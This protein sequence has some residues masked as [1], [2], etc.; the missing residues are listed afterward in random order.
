MDALTQLSQREISQLSLVDVRYLLESNPLLCPGV[1]GSDGEALGHELRR[2][3]LSSLSAPASWPAPSPL[4]LRVGRYAEALLNTVTGMKSAVFE[5]R[6]RNLQI[7][8][9]KQT[10]GELDLVT[11]HPR[12]NLHVELAVKLY[13]GL[14]KYQASL[15]GWVGPN[16]RDTL[17][18][19]FRH[20]R[21]KQLPLSQSAAAKAALKLRAEA[22]LTQQAW[23]KG[24]LFHYHSIIA[25]QLPE[26]INPQ[27]HSG[28]WT[29]DTD[30]WSPPHHSDLIYCIPPKPFW[31]YS[32]PQ[33]TPVYNDWK[34]L[35]EA[36]RPHIE[37]RLTAHVLILTRSSNEVVSRG[38]IASQQW[39][40]AA[41]DLAQSLLA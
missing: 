22:S 10:I 21:D 9:G 13:L 37:K 24:Y 2:A 25:D 18:K 6:A 29:L 40:Q 26:L 15:D 17:G 7:F 39:L 31:I 28:W 33:E 30:E 11:T 38:F 20:L 14:P 35:L 16:P 19:K 34:T 5:P 27:H 41:E 1:L 12:G 3:L 32:V 23:V 8:E 4:P 36:A